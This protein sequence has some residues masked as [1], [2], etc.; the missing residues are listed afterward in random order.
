MKESNEEYKSAVRALWDDPKI[1]NPIAKN[2]N[3]RESMSESTAYPYEE[4]F[5]RDHTSTEGECDLKILEKS[6]QAL[7]KRIY[8]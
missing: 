8:A 4:K 2:Y 7:L 6:R 3:T 5:A 1:Y